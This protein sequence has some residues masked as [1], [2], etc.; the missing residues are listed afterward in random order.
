MRALPRKKRSL[1]DDAVGPREVPGNREA[2]QRKLAE[3]AKELFGADFCAV[4]A[5]NPITQLLYS[6]PIIVGSLPPDATSDQIHE[7][8]RLLVDTAIQEKRLHIENFS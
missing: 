3:E 5:V 8:L 1:I 7:R 6:A 2:T 4:Q